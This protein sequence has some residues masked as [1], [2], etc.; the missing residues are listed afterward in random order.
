MRYNK[1]KPNKGFSL[2]EVVFGAAIFA[3]VAVSVYQGFVVINLLIS[4]SRDK[5]DAINL[6]N[7]E[8]ELVRN[9]AYSDVG[10]QGGIPAGVLQA[11]STKV[12]DGRQ[13]KITRTVRNVDDPFDGTISSIPKDL[14]PADYKIVQISVSCDYCKNPVNF[15]AVSNIAPK[16]LETA[17]TNGALFIRV[18]DASGQPVPQASVHV[19]NSLLGIDINET[20]D[21]DGLLAIVDAPP[22]QNSYRI[23]TTKLGYTT[24]RTY[25]TSTANP[26]PVKPDATVLLQQLTQVSF[27]IDKLSGISLRTVTDK[28]Q[29]VP[30]VPFSIGGTK[31]IGEDPDVYKWEGDFTTDSSGFKGLSGIEWDVFSFNTSGGLYL[32]G[33][34]PISPVSVLPD[35]E[36]NINLVVSSD[37]PDFLLVGVK[38]AAT[39]FP[40]SGATVYLSGVSYGETLITDRGFLRQTDWSGGSGQ[41]EF[42][43]P[44]RYYSSDGNIEVNDPAG[45]LKLMNT[46]GNYAPFGELTSSIFDTG[47]SSNWSKIDILPT[48]QPKETGADPIRFKIATSAS[49]SPA[50]WDFLG[51]DGTAASYYTITNNNINPIH[52]GDRYLRYKIFLRTADSSF[53]PNVSDFIASFSSA[54]IPPG[55]VAFSGLGEGSYTLDVQATGYSAQ[56]IPVD[57]NSAWQRRDVLLSP[58]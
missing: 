12:V 44:S 36:Q 7:G 26:N 30:D 9:L 13:F 18:F 51:P 49:S 4:A 28:C 47:T 1:L 55:Q 42:I 24:E 32:S 39:G 52:N 29:P 54:C 40:I 48:D 11:T 3:I 45:E 16:N 53:T 35:S 57:I 14:S 5:L 31:L 21:N 27:I 38:D 37:S 17:S 25:A 20:T 56:T 6:V 19:Q 41:S 46:L 43:D 8:F 50:S 2:V 22:A 34:D 23:T 15:S 10:L 33:T 58:I